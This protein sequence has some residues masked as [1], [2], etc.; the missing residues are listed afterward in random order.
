MIENILKHN[1]NVNVEDADDE[2]DDSSSNL[3]SNKDKPLT[4]DKK[5]IIYN[6]KSFKNES[7][8]D[9]GMKIL[10]K[11]R[12]FKKIPLKYNF[13]CEI[14]FFFVLFVAI[15]AFYLIFKPLFSYIRNGIIAQSFSFVMILSLIIIAIV[16]YR[17]KKL[18]S[19]TLIFL[20]FFIAFFVHLNYML[21]TPGVVRQHDTWSGGTYI[22]QGAD[23]HFDYALN[24]YLTGHLPDY[25]ITSTEIYQ[26]YHPPLNAFI[27]GIF[28]KIF[29]PFSGFTTLNY[30]NCDSYV[31]MTFYVDHF[32]Y[33]GY[34]D[35]SSEE[36]AV[37]ANKWINLYSS[38]QILATFYMIITMYFLFKIALLFIKKEKTMVVAAVFCFFFPR[39]VQ[40]GGQLN[41]DTLSVMLSVLAL[42][43]QLKWAKR[44]YE[45]KWYFNYLD[46][47]AS[48]LFLGL[49]MMTKLNAGSIAI[50]MAAVFIYLL[51]KDIKAKKNV[52]YY[53]NF[54]GQC[55][56]FFLLC[57][58]LG[59]WY[60][61]YS[62]EVLG[63]PLGFVFNNINHNLLVDDVNFFYRFIVPISFHDLANGIFASPFN[64]YNLPTY[65]VKTSLFGEFGYWQ[66]ELFTLPLLISAYLLIIGA[67]IFFV[68]YLVR[69]KSL[70]K[71]DLVFAVSLILGEI[72]AM[73]YFNITMPYGCTMDFRYIVP[74]VAGFVILIVRFNDDFNFKNLDFFYVN[75][76]EKRLSLIRNNKIFD[77]LLSGFNGS[78]YVYAACTSLFYLTCI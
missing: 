27:Q 11:E 33:L 77:V 72:V 31:N 64:D 20:L 34:G 43:Y 7:L 47:A 73:L 39:L 54:V 51:V 17:C 35:L 71:L 70:D 5:Q 37:L 46:L 59:L 75:N 26:F 9:Y 32:A 40:L 10:L 3:S 69:F 16:L 1:M 2:E 22:W 19:K 30:T 78:I 53:S 63:L 6:D 12:V 28:M 67:V 23:A 36:I 74:I 8:D 45:N 61:V 13:L 62:M 66:G 15:F 76:E 58:P 42:Y 14:A 29:E 4:K 24:F 65:I 50:A 68:Y 18:D 44:R 25:N 52:K 49:A 57:A 48:G 60:Q 21:V 41:N 56:V 55:L 38:C